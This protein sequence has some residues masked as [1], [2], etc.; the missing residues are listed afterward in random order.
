MQFLSESGG[1]ATEEFHFVARCPV[2]CQI[3]G[4]EGFRALG[5]FPQPATWSTRMELQGA[6]RA[7]CSVA[8][9]DLDRVAPAR[10]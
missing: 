8:F 7:K 5:M 1:V 2:R 9:E 6:P 3:G 4:F 10:L